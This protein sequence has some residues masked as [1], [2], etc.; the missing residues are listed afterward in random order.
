MGVLPRKRGTPVNR[1]G[2][3]GSLTESLVGELL[4]IFSL[5]LSRLSKRDVP[6]YVTSGDVQIGRDDQ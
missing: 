3:S 1:D 2:S 5:S 4:R 6:M